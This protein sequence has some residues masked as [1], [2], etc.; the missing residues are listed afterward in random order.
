[1]TQ[2]DRSGRNGRSKTLTQEG[3]KSLDCFV[4]TKI[5]NCLKTLDELTDLGRVFDLGHGID[6]IGVEE[7]LIVQGF[8]PRRSQVEAELY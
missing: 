6:P 3:R 8:S 4:L 7:R 1:V 5:V 2:V